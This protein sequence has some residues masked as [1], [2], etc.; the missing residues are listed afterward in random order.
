MKKFLLTLT[1][2]GLLIALGI[3]SCGGSGK[4]LTGPTSL[5][6]ASGASSSGA[7]SG[8]SPAGS[9]GPGPYRLFTMKDKETGSTW[10][11]KGE[12]VDGPLKGKT[13]DQIPAHNAMWFAWLAFW[14]NTEVYGVAQRG[15]GQDF[16]NTLQ[17]PQDK[18]LS[19]GVPPDGIPALTDPTT[20]PASQ[21]GWGDGEMVSGVFFAGEARA[22]PQNIG[23]WHEIVNDKVGGHS[24]CYT[25]CPLT[26]TGLVFDG[27]GDQG[28]GGDRITLGVSGL[29]FNTNLIMYDRRDRKTLYPQ[30]IYASINSTPQELRLLP[31][32]ETTWGLWKQLYPR[33][34]V[35]SAQTGYPRNYGVYPYGSYREDTDIFFPLAQDFNKNALAKLFHPKEMALGLR[36]I[37]GTPRVYPFKAMGERAALNET[38]DGRDILI[39]WYKEGLLAIPYNR[40]VDGRPLMFEVVN[41]S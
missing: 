35:V 26:G 36:G 21:S 40:N 24:V 30:M 6:P 1:V 14:G 11:V 32:V 7:S 12:A 28:Q 41:P 31:V 13:L 27:Q 18:I 38:L 10:N 19:G 8:S 16:R 23:W 39:V 34:S 25:F 9:I 17:F 37:N 20:V 5:P 22:Y 3:L 15:D 2:L 33:T 29:L 4:S